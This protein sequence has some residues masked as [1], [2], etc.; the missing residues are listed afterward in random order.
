MYYG[1]YTLDTLI[2]QFQT[3]GVFTVF[4][5]FIL[6]FAIV[7][8]IVDRMPIFGGG[9]GAGVKAIVSLAVAL[10]AI[11]NQEVSRIMLYLFQ[12]VAIGITILLVLSIFLLF[13][14]EQENIK[15]LGGLVAFTLF[16]WG[17]SKLGYFPS[18]GRSGLWSVYGPTIAFIVFMLVI[19]IVAIVY[20][21]HEETKE[22][23]LEFNPK[24]I[25]DVAT[26]T[27]DLA[28]NV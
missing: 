10:F 7:Y 23:G 18:I 2:Q 13:F 16:I 21:K 6:I 5:P 14:F 3:W 12:N 26:G 19:V 15:W 27:G 24:K 4:L 25:L 9:K 8:S 20:G 22:K 11:T 17:I 1:F 28:K